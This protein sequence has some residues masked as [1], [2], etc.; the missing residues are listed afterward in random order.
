MKERV[1]KQVIKRRRILRTLIVFIEL[2]VSIFILVA[3]GY[4]L[5]FAGLALIDESHQKSI[6]KQ[7][8]NQH[9]V[10][11]EQRHEI[12]SYDIGRRH[13]A[14]MNDI[15]KW[16]YLAN[17][18]HTGVIVRLIVLI[19]VSVIE[20]FTI[21]MIILCIKQLFKRAKYWIRAKAKIMN[22]YIKLFMK[23]IN[24]TFLPWI[25]ARWNEVKIF[26]KAKISISIH[27]N[28]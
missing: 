4:F 12:D 26:A 20:V 2:M 1:A 27:V 21:Y 25:K 10:T 18:T 23:W 6:E 9:Y 28:K 11:Y 19:S 14:E 24:E 15:Y 17:K 3:G 7:V 16:S 22:Q 5:W 8:E 13:S